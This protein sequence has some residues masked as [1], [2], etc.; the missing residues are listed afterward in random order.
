M[1]PTAEC[2]LSLPLTVEGKFIY[3]PW[4]W[5]RLPPRKVSPFV[6]FTLGLVFIVYLSKSDLFIFFR[7]RV[8]IFVSFAVDAP[9]VLCWVL[10]TQCFLNVS[11]SIKRGNNNYLRFASKDNL[12]RMHQQ[13]NHMSDAK[14]SERTLLKGTP[15]VA[16][17]T[18]K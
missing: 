8:H 17:G 4:S 2:F 1:Q 18:K 10:A 13:Q 5:G 15:T 6:R 11:P 12:H 7:S 3:F 9:P 14:E 16:A